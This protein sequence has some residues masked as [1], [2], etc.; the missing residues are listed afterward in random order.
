MDES[1]LA[2][3]RMEYIMDKHRIK[4]KRMREL[5]ESPDFTLGG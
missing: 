3:A 1:A 4:A 5:Q 2:A